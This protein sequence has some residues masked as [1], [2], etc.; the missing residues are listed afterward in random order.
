M[1]R[2]LALTFLLLAPMAISAGWPSWDGTDVAAVAADG[3]TYMAGDLKFSEAYG[4][5]WEDGAVANRIYYDTEHQVLRIA[6]GGHVLTFDDNGLCKVDGESVLTAETDPNLPAPSTTGNV[7]TSNGSAWTSSG[8]VSAPG[9]VVGAT[10]IGAGPYVD[11]TTHGNVLALIGNNTVGPDWA[12]SG[13]NSTGYGIVTMPTIELQ[14][15]ASTVSGIMSMPRV[16]ADA[17]PRTIAT[18]ASVMASTI[19]T[20]AGVTVTDAYGLYAAQPTVGNNN[21]SI[22]AEG[23]VA[24]NGNIQGATVT[25]VGEAKVLGTAL[26]MDAATVPIRWYDGVSTY[27]SGIVRNGANALRTTNG[28]SG[29]G[30]M[31][32]SGFHLVDSTGNNVSKIT[33]NVNAFTTSYANPGG[34]GN[35]TETNQVIC[36]TDGTHRTAP[37]EYDAKALACDGDLGSSTWFGPIST[38]GQY[39]RFDFG[40]GHAKVM[41]EA[42]Y[43]QSDTATHGV[44]KWQGSDNATDWTSIGADFTLG[45]ATT[46]TITTLSAN[47]TSYRY[48]QIVLVSGSTNGSSYWHEFEFKVDE[49]APT[50]MGVQTYITNGA[51]TGG[52]IALQPSAG[53]VGVGTTN[54]AYLLDVDGTA[55]ATQYKLSA[56]NTAPSSATDTGTLGEIRVAADY[57]YVCT[58][59]NTWVRAALA[60]WP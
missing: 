37:P 41:T 60:T 29:Y 36:T 22:Y 40:S 21:Y 20:E 50:Y 27:D 19:T 28:S 54:P 38:P 8:S 39:I 59:T 47:T 43:Y 16:E 30:R 6:V 26:T 45:G 33:E 23:K 11:F 18:V 13:G 56:L 46:N 4:L 42:K 58:A 24:S 57:I 49:P 25:S 34:S 9:S 14:K 15:D 3:K 55:Q 5:R 31:D 48:Y 1:K 10:H 35:R 12:I 17:T 44:W 53:S 51:T 32:A 2:L 7:L 52:N